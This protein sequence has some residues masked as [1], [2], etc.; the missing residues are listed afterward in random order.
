[1][2]VFEWYHLTN[3][4]DASD[5]LTDFE[6]ILTADGKIIYQYQTIEGSSMAQTSLIGCSE[7]DCRAVS[8][9]NNGDQPANEP[10]D[11][12]AIL[13]ENSDGDYVMSGDV[14]GGGTLDVA[15]VTYL[16]EYLFLGGP[17]PV[18]SDEGDI[19]C[20]GGADVADL[21]YLVNYLFVGGPVPCHYL[22]VN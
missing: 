17:P 12:L 4:G 1:M 6:I 5:S 21:T 9:F 19:D 3:K 15:D 20:S 11:G 10:Y 18:S 16:V 7:K 22:S 2:T 13:I 14:D 8:H